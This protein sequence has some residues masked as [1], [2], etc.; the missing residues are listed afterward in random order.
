MP[1]ISAS[2]DSAQR[3]CDKASCLSTTQPPQGGPRAASARSGRCRRRV[4]RALPSSCLSTGLQSAARKRR[5]AAT[6][7]CP[8]D[9][10]HSQ[11]PWRRIVRCTACTSPA[12]GRVPRLCRNC[13]NAPPSRPSH[14]GT[15]RRHPPNSRCS[16]AHSRCHRRS[17]APRLMFPRPGIR[18]SVSECYRR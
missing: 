1:G 9:T 11:T 18:E 8:P 7:H 10:F 12:V 5:C 6:L 2:I 3:T 13:H 14:Q 4:R 15:G 16:R 17:L